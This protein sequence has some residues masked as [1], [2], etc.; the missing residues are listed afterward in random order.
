MKKLAITSSVLEKDGF[1][2]VKGR[3]VDYVLKAKKKYGVEVMPVILP[4]TDDDKLIRAYAE[5][6][7]G[8]IFSGGG[9]IDP[10]HYGEED[11]GCCKKIS[12]IRDTFELS[13]IR[14]VREFNKPVLGICRGLQVMAVAVGATLWQDIPSETGSQVTHAKNNGE[15]PHFV[16][17]DGYLRDIVGADIIQT[18]S[19][20]HQ[21]IDKLGKGLKAV[22]WSENG[23]IIEGIEHESL[24]I[25]AV[26]WH[27]ERMVETATVYFENSQKAGAVREEN[28]F[29]KFIEICKKLK[30]NDNG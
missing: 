16:R 26:Q 15:I 29:K 13:L 12:E 17:T 22:A 7:D 28:L 27:P 24:P 4:Q 1:C 14:Y 23:K 5:E 6:Y 9:D 19:Y 25:F 30:G 20:H 11:H 10:K 3:Y 21:A 2:G 8:F 18:N